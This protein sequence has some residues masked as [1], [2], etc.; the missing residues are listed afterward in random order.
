MSKVTLVHPQNKFSYS[1]IYLDYWKGHN[2]QRADFI[3]SD[4]HYQIVFYSDK[5]NKLSAF[6]LKK[7]FL[8]IYWSLINHGW[9]ALQNNFDPNVI[10]NTK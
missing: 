4:T 7:E 2:I 5:N 8:E 10:N 9:K 3:H 6:Y 1:G